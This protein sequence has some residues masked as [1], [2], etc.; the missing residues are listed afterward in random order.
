M[1]EKVFF[2]YSHADRG[3]AKRVEKQLKGVLKSESRDFTVIDQRKVVSPGK[4][5]RKSLK[6]AMDSASTVVFLASPE[7]EN[8]QW[9][10]YEAGLADALGKRM[11]VVGKKGLA[12]RASLRNLPKGVQWIDLD[13]EA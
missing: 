8:S 1:K 10:N 3:L 5:V 12:K 6:A 7:S 2:S 13:T 4:D 11:V 9:M